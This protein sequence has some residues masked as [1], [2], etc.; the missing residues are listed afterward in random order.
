MNGTQQLV[1][2]QSRTFR[3][4][5][6]ATKRGHARC[7]KITIVT[8]RARLSKGR[9]LDLAQVQVAFRLHDRARHIL[10][11]FAVGCGM[12]FPRVRLVEAR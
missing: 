3:L 11:V 6:L 2:R 12:T 1:G 9:L 10:D 7:G 4:K 8:A 5:S